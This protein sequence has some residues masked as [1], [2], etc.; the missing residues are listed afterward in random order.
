M[1]VMKFTEAIQDAYAQTMRAHPEVFLVGVGLIDPKAVFGTLNGLYKEFGPERVVEGPLAEQMLTGF[2]FGAA[3]LGLRP[4]LIHHRVDFLPLTW[5]QIGNHMAKWY[6]MFGGQQKVP[7]VIRG[8]VGRGWGNGPQHTQSLHGFAASTPGV[9]VVVPAN[10]AEAK[11]LMVSA[12]L[13]DEP[14]I[15]IDHRWLHS[16]TGEVPGGLY[17]I[18]IGKAHVM[19]E[20]KDAT[21]IAIGPMVQEA[22]IAAEKLAALGKSVEVINLRTVRPIDFDTIMTSVEKTGHLLVADSDWPHFGV[23]SAIISEVTQKI[24]KALKHAPSAITWPNH[25][26]PASYAL[27]VHYYP[28]AKDI[29]NAVTQM[30]SG[31]STLSHHISTTNK[32]HSGTLS[33]PF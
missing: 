14:V 18:P 25:P 26:V 23:A 29:V 15:Y 33:G 3:T 12:I 22:M 4:V 30:L 16:D 9:K 19:L 10:A 20:G 5:D 13:D 21:I 6:Y 8:I 7:C 27:D 17:Q 24:F 32:S 28:M 11:G 2:A 31:E 1:S